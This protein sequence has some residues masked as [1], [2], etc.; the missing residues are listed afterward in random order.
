MKRIRLTESQLHRVIKESVNKILNEL[1]GS[2]VQHAFNSLRDSGRDEQADNIADIYDDDNG[3]Y[4][5]KFG[6][7]DGYQKYRTRIN[8]S[9][10][11]VE[12]P[13]F[14][15]MNA[16]HPKG[17]IYNSWDDYYHG[18]DFP[19][20][21]MSGKRLSPNRRGIDPNDDIDANDFK[22]R[23]GKINREIGF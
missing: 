8:R 17:V 6:F 7:D 21:N 3:P 4:Q 16:T 14:T 9:G 18:A 11:N 12:N 23:I 1:K 22:R 15:K 10:T 5:K 19:K 13:P 2:T 20:E